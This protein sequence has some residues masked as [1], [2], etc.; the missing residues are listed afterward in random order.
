[1]LTSVPAEAGESRSR[2]EKAKLESEKR[3]TIWSGIGRN[4]W[5]VRIWS[6]PADHLSVVKDSSVDHTFVLLSDVATYHLL[7]RCRTGAQSIGSDDHHLTRYLKQYWYVTYSGFGPHLRKSSGIL[8]GLPP[9]EHICCLLYVSKCARFYSTQ[10][11]RLVSCFL[12]SDVIC[13]TNS[14]RQANVYAYLCGHHNYF[15]NHRF[16]VQSCSWYAIFTCTTRLFLLR[17][18]LGEFY[19]PGSRRWV[20]Q[21]VTCDT[22]ALLTLFPEPQIFDTSQI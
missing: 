16:P 4:A 9:N 22:L 8:R 1:M 11:S 13:C 6:D 2:S 17:P 7:G 12:P 15:Q 5:I 19:Q 10:T 18:L 20:L 14:P 3:G 21:P